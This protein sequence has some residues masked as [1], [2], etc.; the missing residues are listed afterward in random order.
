MKTVSAIVAVVLIL[1]CSAVGGDYIRIGVD[2]IPAGATN[3]DIPFY[4]ERTCSDPT[5]ILGASNGFIVTA[6]GSA[7]W[8]WNYTGG[9]GSQC[10]W[11]DPAS[12]VDWGVG[13]QFYE[14]DWDGISPDMMLLGG[15]CPF[16]GDCGIF[17]IPTEKPYFHWLMDVGPGPGEICIDSIFVPPAGAWN[18]LGLTCGQGG[19]PK[20]PLLV[21]KYGSDDNHPISIT[22]WEPP[23][24]DANASGQVDIDDVVF[25]LNYI[26]LFGSAPNPLLKADCDCSQGD[27]PVDIDDLIFLKDFIFRGGPYPCDPSGDGIPDC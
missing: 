10:A 15:T 26:F 1:S 6:T 18:W 5:Q 13:M 9:N 2:S 11:R 16:G 21:D 17:V 14:A 23:C 3:Y 25:L 12:P 8:T 24:G 4:I 7:T 22:V 27:V 20:R 19:A